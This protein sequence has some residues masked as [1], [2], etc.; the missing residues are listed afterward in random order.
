MK[1]RKKSR[2][3]TA[4]AVQIRNNGSHPY[5]L[6][7]GYMPLDCGEAGVYRAI[8]EAVPVVD[9][10]VMKLIRLCGG[11]NVLCGGGQAEAE[12]QEFVRTVPVGRGQRGLE[13]FLDNYLD[14]MIT[15]GRA[16]GEIVPL[17]NRDIAA[18][19]CGNVSD[20][21]IQ[22]GKSPLEFVLCGYDANGSIQPFPRQHLLLFTPYNPEP[23]APYGV[24]MLRGMPFLADILLKIYHCLALNWERAGNVR[25]SVVYKPQGDMLDKAFARDRAEEIAREWS[26]AMQ[27]TKNGD[28]RDFVAVG[29]VE[30][31]V[32]GADGQVLDSEVPVRQILEQ[33]IAKT[34]L[35]PFLLGLTWASTERM[36]SQQ[37]DLMTSELTAVRRRVTPMLEKICRMWL[38]MHGYAQTPEIVWDPINLQDDVEEAKAR[39]YDAQVRQILQ[40]EGMD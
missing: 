34:G 36:S 17:G 25:Y 5:G 15:C 32:I 4:A 20:V 14:S 7:R 6:L 40:E 37:A 18:V 23:E 10:A 28:V 19:F 31:K 30:I 33:L 38:R 12:L 9:A 21:Q 16:V 2:E 3:K 35:P 22:E 27:T 8:R 13:S 29:D 39:L 24:S 26:G 11:F 1:R